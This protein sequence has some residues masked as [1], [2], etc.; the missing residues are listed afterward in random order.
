M[1]GFTDP[2][3][4]AKG[5]GDVAHPAGDVTAGEEFFDLPRCLEEID[6]VVVVL[7]NTGSHDE[8]IGVEY[9]I[10]FVEPDL[11]RKYLVDPLGDPDPVLGG[12]S[13]FLFVEGHDDY[14]CP[15][16]LNEPRT[17]F[18]LFLSFLERD[19]VDDGLSLGALEPCLDDVE[20]GTVD[21]EWNPGDVRIAGKIV[22]KD[23]HG[24]H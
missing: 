6:G 22:Q 5:E 8:D 1:H 18:E 23:G 15:V 14:R 13:L 9:N 12:R 17:P 20:I 19:G 2:V 4:P 21:H 16:P 3:V 10:A 24:V 11:F 7:L